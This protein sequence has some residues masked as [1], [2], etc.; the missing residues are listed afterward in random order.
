MYNVLVVEEIETLLSPLAHSNNL[1]DLI[2]E[3]L[4]FNSPNFFTKTSQPQKYRWSLLPILICESI[5]GHYEQAIP[6][7]A[8]LQLL[9]GAA[10]LF[11]DIEDQDNPDSLPFKF[12]LP[13]ATNVATTMVILAEK[14][15]TCLKIRGVPDDLIV[16][17]MDTINTNYIVACAGQHLDLELISETR[18]TEES[19]LNIIAMKSAAQIECT[20]SIGAMLATDNPEIVNYFASFGHN[21]G[22]AV[23][24]TNDIQ[25]ITNGI[26]ITRR[27]MT[28]PVIFSLTQADNDTLNYLNA[29][30]NNKTAPIFDQSG[31]K[32]ILFKT[33]AMHYANIKLEF[34]RQAAIDA[35]EKAGKTG[36]NIQ[37]IKSLLE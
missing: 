31:I 10:E 1:A 12:G 14:A 35:L 19:Y 24:I 26:D 13:I 6:V 9:K 32:D 4:S 37:V 23:Q 21:L 5:S 22:M 34:Y 3:S 17:I 20:C 7:T 8:A 27:K 33:G 18:I 30:Y 29:F 15:I 2:R 11:D 25:G 36:A 28:L 16:K